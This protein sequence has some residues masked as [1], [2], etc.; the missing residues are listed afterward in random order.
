MLDELEK[1]RILNKFNGLERLCDI[2]ITT[3]AWEKLDLIT[4]T[5]KKKRHLLKNFYKE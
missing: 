3:D 4:T 2:Y 5:M 1:I